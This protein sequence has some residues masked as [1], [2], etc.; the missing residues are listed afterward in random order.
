MNPTKGSNDLPQNREEIA[1]FV[2]SRK[3]RVQAIARTK[4]T[5]STRAVFDSEDV[6]S[7]VI[8]RLDGLAH[9]GKLR[10][11]S[12]EELWALIVTIAKN[13]ATS[14][15]RLIERARDLLNDDAT[16]A[17]LLL[18]R[19][20]TCQEDMDADNLI[21]E[22]AASIKAPDARQA[23]LLRV[24]GATHRAIASALGITEETSRQ[25]WSVLCQDLFRRFGDQAS[26]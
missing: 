16:F 10:L 4:L 2:L 11:D 14:K 1:R 22:M 20:Q 19:A 18:Q 6:L 5:R 25:R 7:S 24:R 26:T 13:D 9:R 12:E 23:F 17:T 15:T 8:R 3:A 21:L